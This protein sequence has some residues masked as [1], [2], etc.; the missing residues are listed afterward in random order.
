MLD[1][2]PKRSSKHLLTSLGERI[3]LDPSLNSCASFVG[4]HEPAGSLLRFSGAFPAL[5][6]GFFWVFPT[7]AHLVSGALGRVPVL[8]GVPSKKAKHSNN[9]CQW[10]QTQATEMFRASLN[11]RLRNNLN[12]HH[13]RKA[14]WSSFRGQG[15]GGLLHEEMKYFKNI[16]W[17][18]IMFMI[19]VKTS[20]HSAESLP[21]SKIKA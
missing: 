15:Y 3:I 11:I 21:P 10:L 14:P 13:S 17:Q 20:D 5:I 18:G 12:D 8:T 16:L 7:Q 2:D 19:S 1:A 6:S 9:Q 4:P